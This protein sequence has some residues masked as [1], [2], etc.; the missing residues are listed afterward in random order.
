MATTFKGAVSTFRIVGLATANHNLFTIFNKTGSTKF[1]KLKRLTIQTEATAVLATV[2][3]IVHATR[4]TALPTGGTVITKV[5]FDSTLTADA[6]IEMMQATASDGG[7]ATTITAT[8]GT[9]LWASFKSRIHTAVGQIL[10]PDEPLIPFF[11]DV[12]PIILRASQGILVQAV[13]A[14][15]TTDH[16]IVNCAFEETDS[17]P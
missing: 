7:A 5:P 17:L 9:R 15:L 2:A 10:F 4:I 1:I 3:P 6:N 14:S 11:C 13:Q 16:Y 12:D 8:A